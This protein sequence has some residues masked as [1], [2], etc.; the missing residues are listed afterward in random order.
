MEIDALMSVPLAFAAERGVK[1]PM[2][3]AVVAM[4]KLRARAAGLY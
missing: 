3:D 1:T 4:A 2:L